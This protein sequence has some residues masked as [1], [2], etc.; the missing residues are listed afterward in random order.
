MALLS[1]LFFQNRLEAQYAPYFQN[2]DLSQY[3]AGNQNWGISKADDGRLYVANTKG[4]LEFDGFKWTLNPLPNKTTIRSVHAVDERIYIGSY[5]E[6]G[7]WERN[8]LGQLS[9]T[10]LSESLKPKGILNQEF[11]QIITME[12]AIIFRSFLNIYVYK[13][14]EIKKFEPPSTVLSCSVIEGVL[15]ISTLTNGI[16]TLKDDQ[17]I[18][19]IDHKDLVDAKIITITKKNDQFLISTSLRGIFKYK[20]GVLSPFK[21]EINPIIKEQQLNEFSE[22]G[23]G[24]MIFGTIKNGVYVTDPDGKLLFHIHKENGL[25]NNTVL[26]QFIDDDDQLWLG[27]DN[28]LASA[29]LR[30]PYL[31]Y[32][33]VS[34]NLGA[35]YDVIKYKNTVYIGSNTGLYYLDK[36]NA[37][38]FID[39]SQGQVWDLNEIEGDL[40][41]GHNN[42][43]YLVK[44][45]Q[46]Q[47]ISP[48]TGGWVMKKVLG[49][50]KT[51]IQGTYA[52]L[53]KFKKEPAG[54]TVKHLGQTTMP[55]RFLVLED[56][57]TAWAAHA[58]KGLYKVKFNNSYD[59]ILEV[60]NYEKKG[61][62]SPYNVRVNAIKNDICIKTNEG[63]QKYEPLLDS[64]VP[65]P[66][67]NE[68]F[69]KNSYVISEDDITTLAVKNINKIN[70][71]TF[72]NNGLKSS[73]SNKYFKKR[74]ILGYE[75]ISKLND[76]LFALSLNNGF[77]LFDTTLNPDSA[78]LQ[79][80]YF[81]SILIN[82]QRIALD[83][84]KTLELP[85]KFQ[86]LTV[87]L[88][89]P[90]SKDYFFEYAM[91]SLDTLHWYKMENDKL[92]FSNISYG[93]YEFRFRTANHL[94]KKS[95]SR[96]LMVKV[97][98][99]WYRSAPGYLLF[100]ALFVSTLTLF[101][102]LHHR[103]IKKEQMLLHLKFEEEQKIVLKEKAIENERRIVELKNES[104][105]NEVKL[106]SKQLANTA[107]ALVKKNETL[108]ELKREILLHR[109][110]F[111]NHFSYKN[112]IKK[113]DTSISHKDEWKVFEYNFNQVHEEF[114]KDLKSKHP[115][116]NAKDLRI[117]AYI[118]M[119]LSTKEIAPLLNISLR[120][121]ETQRYRLRAKLELDSDQS[122]TDYLLNFK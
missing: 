40:F 99:P 41:C 100:I 22:M 42:G 88:T 92:E 36:D 117:S 104:L 121:V 114:F 106:K 30:S 1:C 43:T 111:E 105:Q 91:G 28:G 4:L 47:L 74:L 6:F 35:V 86:A 29:D 97:L 79:E 84:I 38:Q 7:F 64:I 53:V 19:F 85:N 34:G 27:L 56:A 78:P 52:G 26:S 71:K 59:T 98:P 63:W 20:N 122:L 51:Y 73:L 44:D 83:T 69:G 96:S 93:D 62:W 12:D 109:N 76:S 8:K 108:L 57:Y 81:E 67:L 50:S 23:N 70:F 49:T 15:Y 61:L 118:K 90:K 2:Y 24:N 11:W 87:A 82:K 107:M 14:G 58:Y 33:D 120:G 115:K 77:M 9:Y 45:K 72:P 101:Y 39:G 119:N 46:L 13:N 102:Y 60:R 94:G 37:L 66:L 18:S 48:H 21:A 80:P 112:L 110:S 17:L 10:S 89:S 16:F 75:N 5:E 54:W 25:I 31:F 103:K 68:N 65:Y 116:L 55:I 95:A 32:N 113:I 3:N